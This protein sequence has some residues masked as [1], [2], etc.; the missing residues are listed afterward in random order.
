MRRRYQLKLTQNFKIFK[1]VNEQSN[2]IEELEQEV[3]NL[4]EELAEY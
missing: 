3:Q 4:R 1:Y 2:E